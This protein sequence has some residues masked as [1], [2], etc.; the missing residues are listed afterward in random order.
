MR[1]MCDS[2]GLARSNATGRRAFARRM[3]QS[4][5]V[6]RAKSHVFARQTVARSRTSPAQAV[7]YVFN[8]HY[9]PTRVRPGTECQPCPR[10]DRSGIYGSYRAPLSEMSSDCTSRVSGVPSARSVRTV[11]GSYPRTPATKKN[12]LVDNMNICHIQVLRWRFATARP[13][14]KR[15]RSANRVRRRAGGVRGRG[16]RASKHKLR[17]RFGL[18]AARGRVRVGRALRSGRRIWRECA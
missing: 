5:G 16:V 18:G 15:R 4:P 6:T 13:G 14:P 1:N 7:T 9:V 8:S 12:E 11:S 3:C 10:F 2:N 17:F